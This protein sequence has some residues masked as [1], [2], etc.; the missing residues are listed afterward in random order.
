MLKKKELNFSDNEMVIEMIKKIVFYDYDSSSLI[1][2]NTDYQWLN[3][4]KSNPL[5]V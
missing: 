1:G 3:K 5:N 2:G 4:M